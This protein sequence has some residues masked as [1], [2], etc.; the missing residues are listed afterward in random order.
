MM[1]SFGVHLNLVEACSATDFQSVVTKTKKLTYASRQKF[2]FRAAVWSGNI[3]DRR[4]HIGNLL[5]LRDV[6]SWIGITLTTI[7]IRPFNIALNSFK[8]IVQLRLC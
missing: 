2:I 5:H 3:D 4:F 8:M 6:I 7:S 1:L